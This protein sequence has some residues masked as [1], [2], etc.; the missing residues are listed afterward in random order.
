MQIELI[1]NR[2]L[3]LEN[4]RF[5]VIKYIC[6]LHSDVRPVSVLLYYTISRNESTVLKSTTVVMKNK[7]V[8]PK[9]VITKPIGVCFHVRDWIKQR[10][11]HYI[12]R[13]RYKK[14]LCVEP[15]TYRI[16]RKEKTKTRRQITQLIFGTNQ[17]FFLNIF[18]YNNNNN[19]NNLSIR[20][21]SP[22]WPPWK[23]TSHD[24]I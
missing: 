24:T 16:T 1:Y 6:K 2:C 3:V 12:G 17:L 11:G 8:L 5:L 4:I 10:E 23:Q 9:V 14:I 15:L 18:R 22:R 21:F 7:Y 13:Q 20:D 19:N